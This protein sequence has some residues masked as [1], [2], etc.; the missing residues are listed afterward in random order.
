MQLGL[1]PRPRKS[2]IRRV[3][4]FD[5]VDQ[6][7]IADA[8]DSAWRSGVDR[9]DHADIV[10]I[11]S[12]AMSRWSLDG[13]L[14]SANS[15]LK[16]DQ[17]QSS[18]SRRRSMI[19]AFGSISRIRPAWNQLELQLVDEA[20]PVQRA[21][22]APSARHTIRPSSGQLVVAMRRDPLRHR[23]G[24]APEALVQARHD[25]ELAAGFDLGMAAE[26]PLEQ[27]RARARHRR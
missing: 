3:S 24:A 8:Q 13:D 16:F 10:A 15:I 19:R 25:R 4:S 2:R 17:Q 1:D 5:V 6:L 27:G 11:E 12:R 21:V 7:L 22:V 18:A 20:R 23:V 26:D 14:P 9:F